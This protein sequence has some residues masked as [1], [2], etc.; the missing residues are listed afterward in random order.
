LYLA[1]NIPFASGW[2]T[3]SN[4]QSIYVRTPFDIVIVV[5]NATKSG[6]T[7]GF[8]TIGTLPIGFRP[9]EHVRQKL[10]E[11]IDIQILSTGEIRYA[12]SLILSGAVLNTNFCYPI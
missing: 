12:S 4:H 9:L 7:V 11:G 8:E 1:L 6:N 2:S 5:L 3:Q 10:L